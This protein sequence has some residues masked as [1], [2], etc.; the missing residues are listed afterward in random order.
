M[1]MTADKERRALAAAATA[2]DE[3][4]L[5]A[6]QE[7]SDDKRGLCGAA[8][9]FF[10]EH[11]GETFAADTRT[12]WAARLGEAVFTDGLDEDKSTVLRRLSSSDDPRVRALMHKVVAGEVGTEINPAKAH[13]QEPGLRCGAALALA[14]LGDETVKAQIVPMLSK[15]ASEPDRAALEV[16]LALLGDPSYIRKE[17]FALRSY[18]IGLAAVM[19]IERFN[20]TEGMDALV[21]GGIEH[22]WAGVS[23][24]AVAALQRITKQDFQSKALGTFPRDNARAWWRAHRDEW[25]RKHPASRQP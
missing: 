15:A 14:T 11:K 5:A 3:A 7:L 6:L 2:S 1:S 10:W 24:E 21:E 20:G 17:H 8:R 22:P 13:D 23:A 16:S 19:A 18:S 9:L 25:L 4:F 12:E